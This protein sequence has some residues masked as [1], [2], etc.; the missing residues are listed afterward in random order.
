[1]STFIPFRY[2]VSAVGL[3]AAIGCSERGQKDS[4][5]SGLGI[6]IETPRL[7]P[8][9]KLNLDGDYVI[10][11][12]HVS[13]HL[14]GNEAFD[15]RDALGPSISLDVP[16]GQLQVRTGFLALA[17]ARGDMS[18]TNCEEQMKNA[19]PA[20]SETTFTTDITPATNEVTFSYPS[21]KVF[22]DQSVGIKVSMG[23]R[24]AANATMT[25]ID[26]ISRKPILNPCNNE[27][28]RKSTDSEGRMT[29]HFP[30]YGSG[31]TMAAAFDFE[32]RHA[33][34]V[35]QAPNPDVAGTLIFNANIENQVASPAAP[36]D[37]FDGDGVSNEQ[38]IAAGTSATEP[39][40]SFSLSQPNRR[41][42]GSYEINIS[43]DMSSIRLKCQ[44]FPVE[45]SESSCSSPYI[46]TFADGD[47]KLVVRGYTYE[48]HLVA[49]AMLEFRIGS[50]TTSTEWIA[51]LNYIDPPG[52]TTTQLNVQLVNAQAT[53]YSYV[54]VN[55]SNCDGPYAF[56]AF[57]NMDLR[58][59]D[60]VGDDGVKTLCVRLKNS[61]GAF[62]SN[63]IPFTWTKASG[64]G[65]G[66][67]SGGGGS[68]VVLQVYAFRFDRGTTD[69]AYFW[70]KAK[71]TDK[72]CI[73]P[74]GQYPTGSMDSCF[75][76]LTKGTVSFPVGDNDYQMSAF[77]PSTNAQGYEAAGVVFMPQ[78]SER[79]Y[80]YNVMWSEA[81]P[82][83]AC[84]SGGWK[85]VRRPRVL[86][87]GSQV[88]ITPPTTSTSKPMSAKAILRLHHPI[89]AESRF[90]PLVL[91]GFAE[92][93]PATPLRV[94]L[95]WVAPR[96]VSSTPALTPPRHQRRTA[97]VQ[98]LV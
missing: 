33:E 14:K 57:R 13:M 79:D 93:V 59:T 85:I 76:T 96:R 88:M 62:S 90:L 41:A 20:Y 29:L 47:Y 95:T 54:L 73:K 1:M 30:F 25:L 42:D 71:N 66:T 35:F 69:T 37:D 58:I 46:R 32:G 11:P 75:K 16:V 28:F 40:R 2:L 77:I 45:T 81:A 9:T 84:P 63:V 36:T 72:L 55:A 43:G 23:G 4:R 68:S 24:P 15:F 67:T 86:Q 51:T 64:G 60:T 3:I 91:V 74:V 21:L 87:R 50:T 38:E 5:K 49:D 22:P 53:Q 70:A 61:T 78:K 56:S 7:A 19:K 31:G 18:A 65:G 39:A 8:G 12:L 80:S 10:R 27:A 94:G 52:S 92:R 17:T 48:N 26:P 83:S 89:R 82:A 6:A 98:T 97:F 44:L 34:F